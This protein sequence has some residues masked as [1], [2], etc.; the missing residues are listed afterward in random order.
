[1]GAGKQRQAGVQLPRKKRGLIA[2]KVGVLAAAVWFVHG[3]V[4]AVRTING[5]MLSR[6]AIDA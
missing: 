4:D 1:M 2:R 3:T 6:F 5:E